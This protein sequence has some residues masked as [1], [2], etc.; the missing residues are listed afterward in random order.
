MFA[1]KI[2]SVTSSTASS[3][4]FMFDLQALWCSR[5]IRY[6]QN[7]KSRQDNYVKIVVTHQRKHARS[8]INVYQ[9]SVG[10]IGI[11]NCLSQRWS[12]D[13]L[14]IVDKMMKLKIEEDRRMKPNVASRDEPDISW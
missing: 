3:A 7:A 14:D 11:A 9:N 2:I 13:T 6:F 1:I 10:L 12:R 5:T 4:Q 8:K